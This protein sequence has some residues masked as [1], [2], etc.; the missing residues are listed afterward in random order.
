MMDAR[1]KLEEVFLAPA[2]TLL[3]SRDTQIIERAGWYQTITPSSTTSLGN[4]VVYSQL[5]AATA[6]DVVRRTIREY[7]TH[8]RPFNWGTGPLTEPSD[9]GAL[10]ERYGFVGLD[11]RGMAIDPAA[12]PFAAS[13][14]GSCAIEL[15]T[16][17]NADDY[18]DGFARGWGLALDRAAI[19]C[20]RSGPRGS[21]CSSRASTA[22]SPGR[23]GSPSSRARPTSSAATCSTRIVAAASIAR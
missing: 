18:I 12:W 23:P 20:A 14:S 11:V 19:C 2:G 5:D 8:G 3:A 17:D 1:A 4:E 21:T 22:R 6:E 10:L 15:V 7:A 13:A 16:R 9:F